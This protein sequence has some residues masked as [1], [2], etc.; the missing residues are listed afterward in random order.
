MCY[1]SIFDKLYKM[2][3]KLNS[4]GTTSISFQLYHKS[5]FYINNLYDKGQAAA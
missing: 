1:N 2:A 4:K 3:S 5:S